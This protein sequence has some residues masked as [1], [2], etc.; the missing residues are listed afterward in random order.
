MN[1][2]L[3]CI[4]VLSTIISCKEQKVK[5]V[6]L[7]ANR[8]TTNSIEN[9]IYRCGD[10]MLAA[11]KRK[12]WITFVKYNHPNMTKRMGGAPAFAAFIKRQMDQIR[13][14]V[15]SNIDLGNILQVVKTPKDEQ[16]V[17]EQIIKMNLDGKT[18]DKKTYLVG[19][20]LD[21]G[22]TWTFFDATTQTGLTPRDIK[23]DVSAALKIPIA[24][25][26]TE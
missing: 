12:D 16:C 25:R 15:M 5:G 22:Y 6:G 4:I 19:E 1:K 14:T 8:D 9:N 18:I 23:P 2:L 3:M 7:I 26:G 24:L 13:D 20:S 11:F 21:Q 17:V 10:S